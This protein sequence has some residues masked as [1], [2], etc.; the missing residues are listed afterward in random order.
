MRLL[1]NRV[2]WLLHGDPLVEWHVSLVQSF[3][4]DIRGRNIEDGTGGALFLVRLERWQE[5]KAA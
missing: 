2:R 3:G 1:R 4:G 5:D